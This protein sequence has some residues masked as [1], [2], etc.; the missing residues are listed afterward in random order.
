MSIAAGYKRLPAADIAVMHVDLSVI[1]GAYLAAARAFPAAINGK[2][3]DIRK[4]VVS[5]HLVRPGDSW[6]GPVIVKTDLNF[7]GRPEWFLYQ[8]GRGGRWAGPPAMPPRLDSYE[9][10]P[11][12]AKVPKS[13]WSTP[14]LI[15]E[16]FLPER[17]ASG[18]HVRSWTFFGDQE[19]CTRYRSDQPIIKVSNITGKE[20]SPV[21]EAM[22][23]ERVRLGFDFGK[24][25]FVVHEGRAVLLDAN[26]TP[27][28]PPEG[29]EY[30]RS[31]AKLA[32]GIESF[33]K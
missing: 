18:F 12:S 16:R 9:I 15:V 26:R 11:S 31:N 6:T 2:A 28:A 21:P 30:D 22:R 7:G 23:A 8:R 29:P 24:F 27:G 1:P 3:R 13:V 25:D 17:D 20:P 4:R 19:R 32:A 5:R 33:L 10:F 14:D